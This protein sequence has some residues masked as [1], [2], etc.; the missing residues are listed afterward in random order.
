M[1][2]D[3]L[4]FPR[5]HSQVPEGLPRTLA[6][7]FH[8]VDVAAGLKLAAEGKVAHVV[9]FKHHGQMMTLYKGDEALAARHYVASKLDASIISK[10]QKARKVTDKEDWAPMQKLYDAGIR[11]NPVTGTAVYNIEECKPALRTALWRADASIADTIDKK[12][13]GQTDAALDELQMRL[14]EHAAQITENKR[15]GPGGALAKRK[16]AS[17]PAASSS[18]EGTDTG[19][20]QRAIRPMSSDDASATSVPQFAGSEDTAELG[21]PQPLPSAPQPPSAPPRSPPPSPPTLSPQPPP[22]PSSRS[23]VIC[24]GERERVI[25]KLN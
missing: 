13:M 23:V 11:R 17:S 19:K 2:F 4:P 20:R 24:E 10:N 25:S 5:G 18:D 22:P 1:L 7:E 12:Q 8:Y 16:R 3:S 15:L 6:P 9:H 21:M 14:H